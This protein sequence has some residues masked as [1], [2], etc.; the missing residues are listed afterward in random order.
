[1][2]MNPLWDDHYVKHFTHTLC[3]SHNC[4]KPVREFHRWGVHVATCDINIQTKSEVFKKLGSSP[5]TEWPP[6][7]DINRALTLRE[8][9]AL[10][11]LKVLRDGFYFFYRTMVIWFLI[12]EE[13]WFHHC[14]HSMP[15]ILTL[16]WQNKIKIQ[17]EQ[18]FQVSRYNGHRGIRKY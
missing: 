15:E 9:N 2:G 14:F 1:M 11:S 7:N 16:R 12:L 13:V 4:T 6:T 18:F 10:F 3:T 17:L 8:R 5:D